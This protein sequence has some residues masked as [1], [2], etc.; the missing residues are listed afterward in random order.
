M[1]SGRLP[2]VKETCSKRHF[3]QSPQEDLTK[4]L[5]LDPLP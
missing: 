5:T 2:F 1:P 3:Q 4:A